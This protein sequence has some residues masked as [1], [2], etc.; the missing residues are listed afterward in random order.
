MNELNLN[1]RQDRV[2]RLQLAALAGLMLI[3]TM[4]VYSATL[5]N[6]SAGDC[7][8]MTRSGYARSSGTRW[9]SAG[10]RPS[11]WWIT[12][13]WPAGRLWFTA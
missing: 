9:V 13:R 7:P 12:I 11:A 10:R 5:T 6:G 3:G 8:G 2:D 4:F 1:E